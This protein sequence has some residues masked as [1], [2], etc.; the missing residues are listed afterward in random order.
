[1]ARFHCRACGQEGTF[2][3]DERRHCCPMCGSRDVQ[4]APSIEEVPREVIDAVTRL[5]NAHDEYDA[6]DDD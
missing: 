4:V 2:E 1:M 6:A 3:Y 5:A